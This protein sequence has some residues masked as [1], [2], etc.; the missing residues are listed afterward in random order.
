M[1]NLNKISDVFNKKKGFC[2]GVLDAEDY[3]LT[4]ELIDKHFKKLIKKSN[5]KHENK[6]NL[7]N[8]HTAF[9]KVNHSAIFTKRN[10]LL[11]KKDCEKRIPKWSTQK[12]CFSQPS[13]LNILLQ[14]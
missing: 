10:R 12:I 13:I 8:Y 7:K 14:S 6:I 2:Y 4:L 3:K 1:I 9:K 5:S 11:G